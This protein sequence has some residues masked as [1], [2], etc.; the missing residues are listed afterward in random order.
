M[1]GSAVA[2]PVA[3]ARAVD[4]AA[5]R[6]LFGFVRPRSAPLL[7]LLALSVTTSLLVLVQPYLTKLLIDDGLLARQFDTVLLLVAAIFLVGLVA[8]LLSGA[9][10][11]F[12]TRLSGHIL[13]DLRESVYR[14]L[15]TLSPA[16]YARNRGGDILTRLDGDVA[17]IQRFAVDSLFAAVSALLGL[18]GTLVFMLLLSWQL[19]LVLVALV[20]LHWLYLRYMR[21]RVQQQT[22]RLRERSSDVTAFLVETVPAMKFIQAV[23]AESREAN[24]LGVLNKLY[25][26]D[27]LQL[28]LIEFATAAVPNTLTSAARALV[29]A[30]GGYWVIQG[31]MALG[32]LIAFSTYLGMAVGPVQGLLGLYMSLFRVQVCLER[33]RYLV[34]A[35]PDVRSSG[36]R[37]P[38][39]GMRGALELQAVSFRYP[40]SEEDILRQASVSFP[41]GCSV[42]I[43]SPSGSG[44][45]TLVDLLLRHYEPDSGCILVDG[46]DI[47]EFG[48]G[49]W[50]RRIA[51]VAQDIVL[52]RGSV[53]DN[54]RYARPDATDEEVRQA[55]RCAQLNALVAR[56]PEG[57]DTP[58]GERGT[59]LSGGEKQRIAI[60]RAL[61]QQPLLV[62]LDEA[63]SAVDVEVERE[64]L[65]AVEEL[66]GDCTRL[67][68]S[69]RRSALDNCGYLLAIEGGKLQSGTGTVASVG[70]G[71]YAHGDVDA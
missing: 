1:S 63:T 10:R 33:V 9:N 62:I 42:G 19:T 8:T 29:F 11:Y 64:V 67:V 57:L 31:Q 54:I 56:L 68:I 15:Q 32:S 51:L 7:A 71:P 37:V 34:E 49:A 38:G 58:V 22:R 40:G 46:I 66:F 5:M 21:P 24:R 4:R 26:G 14:H 2:V 43:Y 52:F 59:R 45:T 27:L 65:Q 39:A 17:E 23:A 47:R 69:H 61:L 30:V 35:T 25:L 13:F 55:V 48:L 50:R 60:A 3:A 44:K 6:W 28:Q 70:A 20:P 16:F 18:V 53:L 36:Q 12:Y 41:A